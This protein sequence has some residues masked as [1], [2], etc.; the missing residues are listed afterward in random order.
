MSYEFDK[1]DV[2]FKE[3]RFLELSSEVFKIAFDIP[4][5]KFQEVKTHDIISS[6]SSN[7]QDGDLIYHISEDIV[8]TIEYFNNTKKSIR[9]SIYVNTE[10]F[11]KG[12]T[13]Y[14][15]YLISYVE[16]GKGSNYISI[17][18]DKI[19]YPK[20]HDFIKYYSDDYVNYLFLV[21]YPFTKDM[22]F[23]HLMNSNNHSCV[24]FEVLNSLLEIKLPDSF[25]GMFY[26]Y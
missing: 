10:Y 14:K 1:A 5:E 8:L 4:K 24:T 9:Y 3:K 17:G 6:C 16:T 12:Y 18:T 21:N 2:Y 20:D 13:K 15:W 23:N 7:L 22:Y 26:D 19:I 25:V 11:K